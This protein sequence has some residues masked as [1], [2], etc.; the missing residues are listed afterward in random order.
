MLKTFIQVLTFKRKMTW[1][2]EVNRIIRPAIPLYWSRHNYMCTHLLHI[3]IRISH[4]YYFCFYISWR[5]WNPEVEE[6]NANCLE[7]MW[8]ISYSGGNHCWV[9]Q[10]RSM[11][12]VLEVDCEVL[13][14]LESVH[15][16]HLPCYT[17]TF[18]KRLWPLA[19]MS[20]SLSKFYR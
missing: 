5:D 20:N 15:W 7:I 11:V 4:V 17:R 9:F 14:R 19:P 16:F 1:V 8:M 10:R 12:D 2:D 6:T 18:V 13:G 3:W